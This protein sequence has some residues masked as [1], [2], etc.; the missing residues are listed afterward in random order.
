MS[1]VED[2]VTEG[3]I[4]HVQQYMSALS[5]GMCGEDAFCRIAA[6]VEGLE[7]TPAE[8]FVRGGEGNDREADPY[9]R[10]HMRMLCTIVGPQ[11]ADEDLPDV[12]RALVGHSDMPLSIVRDVVEGVGG[13]VPGAKLRQIAQS[14]RA[15]Y[16]EETVAEM[17]DVS[18][19]TVKRVSRFLDIP[20][21][22]ER[23]LS[24]AA[25]RLV[26]TGGTVKDL[27]ASEGVGRYVALRHM[28]AARE[29]LGALCEDDEDEGLE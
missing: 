4:A 5:L 13:E 2:Q 14:L 16:A 24:S 18:H 26:F 15:G 22:V 17:F 11:I 8:D 27:M 19:K 25:L 12:V 21:A 9:A 20:E 3:Q 28:K 29:R 1:T 10:L 23:R 6:F 7:S